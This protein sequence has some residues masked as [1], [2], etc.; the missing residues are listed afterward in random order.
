M[1]RLEPLVELDEHPD[2]R[3]AD[4]RHVGQVEPQLVVALA[5]SV[6]QARSVWIGLNLMKGPFSPKDDPKAMKLREALYR[7][8]EVPPEFSRPEVL[9]V[10]RKYYSLEAAAGAKSVQR[11]PQ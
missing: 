10:L 8:A 2:A 6:G 5:H 3:R 11:N 7:G 1:N 4:K 9:Q